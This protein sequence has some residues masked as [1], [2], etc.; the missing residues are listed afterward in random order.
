MNKTRVEEVIKDIT[1]KCKDGDYIFRGTHE[2][3]SDKDK[4][5]KD[6]VRSTFHRKYLDLKALWDD[7]D[8]KALLDGEDLTALFDNLDL[9]ALFDYEDLE[10]ILDD[11]DLKALLN[12]RDLKTLFD[13]L[14]LKDFLGALESKG[15]LEGLGFKGLLD[16]LEF[17][18]WWGEDIKPFNIEKDIVDRV[19]DNLNDYKKYTNIEVL[20]NLRHYGYSV[21]LIDFSLDMHIALFFACDGK[22]DDNGELIMLKRSENNT[23]SEVNYE[24]P[25]FGIINPAPNET[26]K[27]RVLNQKSIFVYAPDGYIKKPKEQI[28]TIES[29]DKKDIL[30]YLAKYHNISRNIV[31]NDLIGFIGNEENYKF[32]RFIFQKGVASSLSKEFDKAIDFYTKA[33]QADPSFT[34]AYINRASA[35]C[36]ASVR[37]YEGAIKDCDKAISQ[38]SNFAQAYLARG[39]AEFGIGRYK[40]ALE[41]HDKAIALEEDSL[42]AYM[43]RSFTKFEIKDY[44]GADE[45]YD[46]VIS[47][48]PKFAEVYMPHYVNRGNV[49]VKAGDNLGSIKYYDKAIKLYQKYA[50]AYRCRGFVKFDIGEY[51]EAIKDFEEAILLDSKLEEEL[52][53]FIKEAK[54]KLKKIAEKKKKAKPNNNPSQ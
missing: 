5:G 49:K 6:I 15:L 26:S 9:E 30:E 29:K 33:I 47:I 34:E 25:D 20:T 11:E 27:N 45:D 24:K 8:L 14:D 38:N 37:N 1:D 23:I 12:T 7:E 43:H 35:R 16:G 40:E 41:S 13:K 44:I 19:R 42:E 22:F 10:A 53:P 2:I 54:E 21:L 48:D 31:Y 39:I 46:E 17:K 3:Y 36:N 52:R 32:S 50:E 51:E 18:D 4:E 28:I